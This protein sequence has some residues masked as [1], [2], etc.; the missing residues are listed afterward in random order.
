M[1]QDLG[2]RDRFQAQVHLDRVPLLG[3]NARS[4]VVDRE[5]LL[6]VRGDHALQIPAGHPYPGPLGAPQQF[7]DLNPPLGVQSYA[8]R[9]GIVPQNKCSIFAQMDDI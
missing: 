6:V 1:I 2:R 4:R 5:A 9:L 7:V 8:G 3:S